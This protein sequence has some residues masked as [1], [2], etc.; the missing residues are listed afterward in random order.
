MYS[1]LETNSLNY[2]KQFGF[3]KKNST[4]DAIAA[5]TEKRRL[6]KTKSHKK[7]FFL[8]L[9]KAFDTLDDEFFL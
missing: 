7:T 2:I 9:K 4:I 5:V 6:D 1:Y 8:D 3:R